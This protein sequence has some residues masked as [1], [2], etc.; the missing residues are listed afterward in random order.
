MVKTVS[1]APGSAEQGEL[2]VSDLL[3]FKIKGGELT[4]NQINFLARAITDRTMDDCQ[5][6]A[7]LMC[8]KL[9][10][11]T[12]QETVALTRAMRDSGSVMC[13]PEDWL[14]ADKHSTGGVG[15]KV[16]LAL[17]P[18]LATLGL[19]VPMI[20]GRG[21]S[22]TGGTLDKLESIPGFR[23][24]LTEEE[25][26]AALADVG[27]CI[28][29]QTTD[30]VPA[31]RRMYATRGVTST[32]FSLPLIVS[33]IVSKKAAESV[34]ALVMDVKY[35]RGAFSKTREEGEQ[36]AQALVN[37]TKGLGMKVCALLTAMDVPI[38]TTIGNALEVREALDCLRGRGP[39]DLHQLVTHLG[40]ELLA[41]S[42]VTASVNEGHEAVVRVLSD[43]SARATFSAMLQKQG[44]SVEV[45]ESLC[46]DE[47]DYHHLPAATHCTP[48]LATTAGVVVDMDAMVVARVSLALGTGRTRIDDP[49][50]YAAGIILL[51]VVGER[52]EA[53]EAWA[54][55]HHDAPLSKMILT[56][57]QTAITINPDTDVFK[58]PSLITARFA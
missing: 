21:L 27:C 14:V 58:K 56:T 19:K 34:K 1:S 10:G 43:G 3:A 31:D 22:H 25:V 6:G 20:S 36:L 16:S 15:D 52:V 48:L 5:L 4:D 12:D 44:V 33:S 7:L 46:G 55:L 32:V 18:A 37:V 11:M 45:A 24:S 57:A 30:I 47:P 51:K 39:P 23:V 8:I 42:G 9:K 13:W 29:G 28:M 40:G 41:M 2:T 17:A 26:H 49:I 35:G 53:G 50:N 38:G 54:E